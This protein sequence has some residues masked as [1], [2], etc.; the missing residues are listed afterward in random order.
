[1]LIEHQQ[2]RLQHQAAAD[3]QHLLLAAAHGA[4]QLLLAVG[5][6]RKDAVDEIERAAA[7]GL[8][9]RHIGADLEIFLHGHFGKYLTA[10]RYVGDAQFRNPVRRQ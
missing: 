7:F 2:P 6:P 5:Q 4:G 8:G 9:L 3:R 1:V 10:L